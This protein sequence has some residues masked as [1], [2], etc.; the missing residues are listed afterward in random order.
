MKYT[1]HFQSGFCTEDYGSFW[2][3]E[4]STS[5]SKPKLHYDQS[6]DT[7]LGPRLI[8]VHFTIFFT[9]LLCWCGAPTLTRGWVCSLRLLLGLVRAILLDFAVSN[10]RLPN[11]EVQVLVFTS[12]RNRVAQIYPRALGFRWH[13][14]SVMDILPRGE[15]HRKHCF[16]EI[17]CCLCIP[18]VN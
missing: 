16:Q 2:A 3:V 8:S 1:M 4:Y 7:R 17:Y 12:P 10:L 18:V 11:L 5:K 14:I 9:P 13:V 6:S 15:P